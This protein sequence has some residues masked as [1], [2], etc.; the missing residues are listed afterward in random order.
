MLIK[1]VIKQIHVNL[2]SSATATTKSQI[3]QIQ[4]PQNYSLA[5]V[6]IFRRVKIKQQQQQKTNTFFSLHSVGIL[7]ATLHIVLSPKVIHK[8]HL[9]SR[10]NYTNLFCNVHVMH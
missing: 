10:I 7:T 4:T 9:Q 2:K 1:T 8:H 5:R 3:L 6:N